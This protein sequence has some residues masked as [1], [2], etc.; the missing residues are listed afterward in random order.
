M[1]KTVKLRE[2]AKF[3]GDSS[4]RRRDMAIFRLFKMAAAAIAAILD[5]YFFLILTVGRLN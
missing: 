5:F 3:R 1:V 4:N 2:G